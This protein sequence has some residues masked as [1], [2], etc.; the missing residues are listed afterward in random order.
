[1]TMVKNHFMPFLERTKVISSDQ[2]AYLK[3]HS[4]QTSLHRVVDTILEGLNE[5][6]FT[7]ACVFD[8][9]KCFDTI[10]HRN[11]LFKLDKYGIRGSALSWFK[12]YLSNRQQATTCHN[13]LSACG[14]LS[15][16]V[17]Q[18]SVL[19]PLLFLL[20]INDVQNHGTNGCLL[21][22]YADDLIV[23]ASGKILSEVQKRL[24]MA[25]DSLCSWYFD[26]RLKINPS[27]SKLI[28]FGSRTQL[29]LVTNTKRAL[30]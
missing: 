7:A 26:N 1:M 17:P 19:G 21:N 23:L 6:E 29:K 20:Y 22:I 12:S 4:T 25:V 2:S 28:V 5:G 13:K 9:S 10:N 14:E 24:Q 27:K 8:I 3:G 16:G 11:L 30:S 15:F 18:G